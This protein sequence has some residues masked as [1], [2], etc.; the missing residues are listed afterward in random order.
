MDDKQK[1]LLK[2]MVLELGKEIKMKDIF[3]PDNTMW[4]V[5][6]DENGN[7]SEDLVY[8]GDME[9]L[10]E[11]TGKTEDELYE[12]LSEYEKESRDLIDTQRE[13]DK[14]REGRY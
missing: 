11:E 6:E 4:V 10:V 2:K 8:V 13:I 1:G 14:A 5:S 12:L 3:T 7:R 9:E